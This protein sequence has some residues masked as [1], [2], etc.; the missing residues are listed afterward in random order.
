MLE[1]SREQVQEAEKRFASPED[2][3]EFIKSI[4]AEEE[5][6]NESRAREKDMQRK[7]AMA[8]QAR[9]LDSGPSFADNAKD[10]GIALV[11]GGHNI[12]MKSDRPSTTPPGSPQTG[13]RISTT[14]PRSPVAP[15]SAF[16]V[17]ASRSDKQQQQK[18]K[19]PSTPRP[20]PTLRTRPSFKSTPAKTP[21]RTSTSNIPAPFTPVTGPR[22]RSRKEALGRGEGVIRTPSK[23]IQGVLDREIDERIRESGGKGYA[24][25]GRRGGGG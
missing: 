12:A 15:A 22:L 20:F 24:G 3:S 25:G 14:P 4:H 10:N 8:K 1:M 11:R 7:K 21:A 19:T 17:T 16:K 18:I 5:K 2:I 13:H 9:G 23:E 6:E